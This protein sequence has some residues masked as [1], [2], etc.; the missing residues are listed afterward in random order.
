MPWVICRLTFSL[1]TQKHFFQIG[2]YPMFCKSTVF[3]LICTFK[4]LSW[5]SII[6]VMA[7]F[8]RLLIC[9]LF[10]HLQ[11]CWVRK[12]RYWEMFSHWE[13]DRKRSYEILK[14]L[15]KPP[16]LRLLFSALATLCSLSSSHK[17][18]GTSRW[19]TRKA[20]RF[21]DFLLKR[22]ASNYPPW[23]IM[24]HDI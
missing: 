3:I 10:C 15:H 8:L 21:S 18:F 1:L 23:D 5:H 22:N 19:K 13:A 20:Q 24:L 17:L 12:F 6:S 14:L 9:I 11:F 2:V 4:T 7:V 16:R